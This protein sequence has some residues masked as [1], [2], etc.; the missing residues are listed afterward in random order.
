[1]ATGFIS[2]A[3]YSTQYEYWKAHTDA[4]KLL[5]STGTLVVIE[6]Y[7]LYNHKKECQVNSRME[8]PKLIGV[9]QQWCWESNTPMIMQSASE[10]KTR[11][12]DDILVKK[13]YLV[14]HGNAF[15]ANGVLINRHVKDSIRH[16]V[17]AA[18]F[19]I[20]ELA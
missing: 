3:D 10:V 17:H 4:L 8:T 6:D 20:K 16:A 11:W 9:M 2:A 18:T 14:K 12:A 19:K 5:A 7:F 15:K 13:G 1:M